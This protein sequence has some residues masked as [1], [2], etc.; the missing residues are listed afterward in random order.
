MHVQDSDVKTAVQAP[1]L[2]PMR[3]FLTMLTEEQLAA[4]RAYRGSDAVVAAVPAAT[5]AA[6][7]SS[8]K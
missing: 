2:A 5:E 4:L 7:A 3:G 8:A 6:K 1:R